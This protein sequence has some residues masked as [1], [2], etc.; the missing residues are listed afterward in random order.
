MDLV[1]GRHDRTAA[2]RR[3]KTIHQQERAAGQELPYCIGQAVCAVYAGA[4][5]AH[6]RCITWLP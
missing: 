6:S 2:L 5:T 3:A 4:A 1:R